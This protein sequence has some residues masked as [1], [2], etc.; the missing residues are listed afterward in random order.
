MSVA[1]FN[2]FARQME[3]NRRL[4]REKLVRRRTVEGRA[5][6][7]AASPPEAARSA[8]LPL[9]DPAFP[10]ADAKSVAAFPAPALCEPGTTRAGA[11]SN[12]Q[13][14]IANRQ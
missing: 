13:S 5:A 12:R 3:R 2:M 14:A 1:Y 10:G 11:S 9:Q 4:M 6:L 7:R 8:A